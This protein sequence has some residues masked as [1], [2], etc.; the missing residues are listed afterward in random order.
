MT[1]KDKSDPWWDCPQCGT[2]TELTDDPG[3]N[4]P[5]RYCPDCE[6]AYRIPR[7]DVEELEKSSITPS[8]R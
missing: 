8:G 2:N 1:K 3:P 4:E 7:V 6:W 5:D